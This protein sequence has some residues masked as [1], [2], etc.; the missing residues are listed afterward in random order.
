MIKKRNNALSKMK[1]INIYAILILTL[2]PI[3]I[4]SCND[5]E[6][7]VE[8]GEELLA[9]D[10]D[11]GSAQRDNVF[12]L[13]PERW[14][15]VEG[16]VSNE[17]A[18]ENTQILN[19]IIKR[20]AEFGITT[21]QIDE[22]DAFFEVN[23]RVNNPKIK[24]ESAILIPSNFELRMS[25]NVFMRVQPNG[26]HTYSLLMVFE[27]ENI[28]INGGNLIGDRWVHDYSPEVDLYG[29]E[30][31]AHDW[32]HIIQI[33][34]GKNVEIDNVNISAAT[35]DGIVV[36]ESVIRTDSNSVISEN[37]TIKNCTIDEIRRNALS[38]L[39]GDGILLENCD[40]TNTGQGPE[41]PKGVYNSSGAYPKYGI[42]FEAYRG[43]DANNNLIEYQR[44][45]NV[46]IRNNR[47]TGNYGGDI[48]L[49]TCSNVN[50]HDNYF[51]SMIAN[52]ASHDITIKDNIM[53]AR[54]DDD[55]NY[56]QFGILFKSK[57][58]PLGKEM[59]Y[60]YT[61]TGNQIKNYVN[62]MVLGGENYTV[63]NNTLTD[64]KAGITFYKY[65]NGAQ[66]YNNTLTS[67]ISTSSGY[68]SLVANTTD[69]SVSNEN[70]A[71]TYRPLNISGLQAN[72]VEKLIFDN[73]TFNSTDNK[74]NSISGS[75]NITV[76]NSQL[77]TQIN[78]FNSTNIQQI[79]NN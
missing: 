28:K 50:I 19:F 72:I 74:V 58:D 39:D 8:T 33:S 26:A 4:L 79:N 37:V 77:N 71:V 61:I 56:Y 63:Y 75:E 46:E 66:L 20:V 64:F 78:V 2:F 32:G 41:N 54:L 3:S 42:S 22:M 14:G 12:V 76:Q 15:I 59:N 69:V 43:R 67:N 25:D 45:E 13:N 60:N 38:F 47:F 53:E 29:N 51:D 44:I 10:E 73:C 1:K 7:F 17:V 40:I 23:S 31:V 27:G 49:Y 16:N 5:D 34:G 65:L 9:I 62:A 24:S 57:F 30:W 11:F 6:V 70:V 35:G 18:K 48:N 68:A 21:L 36:H 52:I 55:G